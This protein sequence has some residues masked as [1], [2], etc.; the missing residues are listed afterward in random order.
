MRPAVAERPVRSPP[1]R[2]LAR[3]YSM[4][5]PGTTTIPNSRA[6][7]SQRLSA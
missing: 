7:K 5:M 3:T 2:V 1:E 4:S 6:V